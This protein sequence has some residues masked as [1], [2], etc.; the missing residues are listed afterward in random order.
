MHKERVVRPG[1]DDADLDAR[2]CVPAGKAIETIEPVADIKIV[3][4]SLAVDGKGFGCD[5]DIDRAPPDISFG[6]GMIYNPLVLGRA[7]GFYS[8]IGN[9]RAFFGD[10]SLLLVADGVLVQLAGR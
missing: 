3:V 5:R 6:I 2:F 8:G 9:Q 1:A 4:R 7:A 10:A